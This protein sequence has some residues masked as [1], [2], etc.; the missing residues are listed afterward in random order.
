M[1]IGG[2]PVA[3]FAAQVRRDAAIGFDHA[4]QVLAHQ[5]ADFHDGGLGG[6][7]T[8]ELEAK[9][10]ELD[11]DLIDEGDGRHGQRGPLRF[12]PQLGARDHRAHVAAVERAEFGH[13]H[14]RV[15]AQQGDRADDGED[16]EHDPGEADAIDH[17][18]GDERGKQDGHDREGH[19]CGLASEVQPFQ[20]GRASPD[21]PAAPQS[22]S[23]APPARLLTLQAGARLREDAAAV[24]RGFGHGEISP[25]CS[26]AARWRPPPAWP[27]QRLRHARYSPWTSRPRP[28]GRVRPRPGRPNRGSGRS[29]RAAACPWNR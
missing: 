6:I 12:K 19:A 1:L 22:H 23:G 21:G 29:A 28:K 17:Q 24:G 14:A 27:A 3:L 18:P 20:F 2:A 7:D 15:G 4:G 5:L 9:A 11:A 26:A 10:I 13:F 8:F 16:G 25:R